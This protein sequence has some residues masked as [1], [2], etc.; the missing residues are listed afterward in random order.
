MFLGGYMV[1]K[2]DGTVDDSE[3]QA[4][5]SIVSPAIF[6]ECMLT[7]KGL[8]EDDIIT[9]IIDLAKEL[10]VVLSVMQKLNMLRDLSIISY[11]DGQID[12]EEVNVL[13]NLAKQLYIKTEFIDRV[14]SD[15]QNVD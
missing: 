2:A 5:S 12:A 4:L 1:S 7:V 6:A 14:I 15:A 10:D 3:I 8:T 13:H 11:A 9:E